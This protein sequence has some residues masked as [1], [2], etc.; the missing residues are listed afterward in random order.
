[1]TGQTIIG[2]LIAMAGVVKTLVL[3]LLVIPLLLVGACGTSLVPVAPPELDEVIEALGYGLAPTQLPEGFEFVRYDVIGEGKPLASVAYNR[4]KDYA[5]HS[6]LIM[7]PQSFSLSGEDNFLFESL[8][9]DW[10]RPDDA[11]SEVKVNGETAYL[12]RGS[13]SADTLEQLMKPDPELLAEYTPGWDYDMYLSLRF[14]FELSPDEIVE[15]MI[16][17]MFYPSEW[18]TGREM[19][20]IAESIRRID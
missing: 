13:W 11:V 9:L 18:I 7:Y 15:V 16:W 12:V 17:A 3:A 10:Q 6:I 19:V 8:G 1:M 2:L 5:S 14:D 4:F 20:K